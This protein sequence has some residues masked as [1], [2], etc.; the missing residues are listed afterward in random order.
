MTIYLVVSI[1]VI[2]FLIGLIVM[3]SSQAGRSINTQLI[4]AAMEGAS[5]QRLIFAKISLVSLA[6]LIWPIAVF[7]KEEK[8][9]EVE[10]PYEIRRQ[11]RIK[12]FGEGKTFLDAQRGWGEY[13][14]REC[15]FKESLT[16]SVHLFVSARPGEPEGSLTRRGAQCQT[17]GQTA[18][19]DNMNASEQ[20]TCACGGTLSNSLPLF[21]KEC[22]SQ[23]VTFRTTAM[24]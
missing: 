22:R 23:D 19:I 21:C 15:G 11:E 12:M 14:C 16:G 2:Y 13:S 8:I 4:L 18:E 20:Y 1:F 10:D 24:T 7:Y 9:P 5:K 6:A 17:C 3:P